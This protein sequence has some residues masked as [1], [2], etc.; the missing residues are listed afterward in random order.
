MSRLGFE[1]TTPVFERARTVRAL[2]GAT[3]VIGT[4]LSDTEVNNM[5][6]YTPHSSMHL[7]D[8]TLN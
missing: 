6:N 4:P 1:L 8:V 3:T 5:C 2:G 7:H